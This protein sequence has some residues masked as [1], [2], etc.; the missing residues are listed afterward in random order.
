[1]DILLRFSILLLVALSVPMPV[2]AWDAEGHELVATMAWDRLNPKAQ[3]AVTDLAHEMESPGHAYDAITLACWMDDLRKDTAMPYH[4]LFLSWH[5]IDLG[6][7]PGDPQ[8][9]LDPGDD[10]E[11]HGN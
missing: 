8:P 5:Y 10:N 2:A 3:K 9:S 1:M 11:V 6:I 4:G 7:D